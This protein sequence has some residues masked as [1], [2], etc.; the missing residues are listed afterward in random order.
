M[1]RL[2]VGVTN[3]WRDELKG[4]NEWELTIYTP[5]FTQHQC[6]SYSQTNTTASQNER[7]MKRDKMKEKII[8]KVWFGLV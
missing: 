8:Y 6:F 2:V 4:W 3:I 1:G 5:F 7:N